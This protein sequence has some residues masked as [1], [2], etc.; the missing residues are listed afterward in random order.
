MDFLFNQFPNDTKCIKL[1]I[2]IDIYGILSIPC[3]LESIFNETIDWDCKYLVSVN[4]SSGLP[5]TKYGVP[6]PP[7]KFI[8]ISFDYLLNNQGGPSIIPGVTIIDEDADCTHPDRGR[9]KLDN[10]NVINWSL[11]KIALEDRIRS[12]DLVKFDENISSNID[13]SLCTKIY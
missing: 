3:D 5:L 6:F 2:V 4:T 12:S 9:L 10:D 13:L 11:L 8:K 1:P 7:I